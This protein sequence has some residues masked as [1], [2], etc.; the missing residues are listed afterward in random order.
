MQISPLFVSFSTHVKSTRNGL[1]DPV[2]Q[3]W[4]TQ[5]LP[6]WL[7]FVTQPGINSCRICENS[8]QKSPALRLLVVPVELDMES[9][10]TS[11]FWQN[12]IATCTTQWF[13]IVE[14]LLNTSPFVSD[15]F[16]AHDFHLQT[17]KRHVAF[18]AVQLSITTAGS[19]E[20]PQHVAECHVVLFL[21]TLMWKE[22][23]H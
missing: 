4:N 13:F 12:R 20:P 5:N 9:Q 16:Q 22:D 6:S 18:G 19:E 2:C 3:L 14:A 8:I 21:D 17:L 7:G 23:P 11:C 1:S 15:H 10:M